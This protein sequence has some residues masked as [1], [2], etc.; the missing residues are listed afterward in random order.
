MNLYRALQKNM[1]SI[2]NRLKRITNNQYMTHIPIYVVNYKNEERKQK[3]STRFN[4]LGLG[5]IFTDP[6]NNDDPRLKYLPYKRT[7]AIMLQHLDSVKHFL[8]KTSYKHCIICEDDIM[9]HNDFHNQLPIILDN[10]DQME[11]DTLLLGYLLP[12]S[13]IPSNHHFPFIQQNNNG[14]SYYGYPDDIWG[15]QMYLISRKQGEAL[16]N[17]F[18]PEFA[19]THLDDVHYNPD[20]TITKDGKRAIIYPM[21]AVEEGVTN[22]DHVG[23][24]DF[25]RTCFERN[26]KDGVYR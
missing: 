26:Y 3:M 25:H 10:F 17:K 21:L 11:L 16:L 1:K 9:I 18:T 22:T 4:D 15:S 19:L 20:W 12:F 24:N 6:V 5:L 8:E 23:Q 7:C 13:Y 2:Q 14:Y